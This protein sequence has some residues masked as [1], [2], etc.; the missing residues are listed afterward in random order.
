MAFF[1]FATFCELFVES[2]LHVND[3]EKC[4]RTPCS[5][6]LYALL[7]VEFDKCGNVIAKC[8]LNRILKKKKII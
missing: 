3:D 5:R 8:H 6:R 7:L 2:V 4:E 1:V